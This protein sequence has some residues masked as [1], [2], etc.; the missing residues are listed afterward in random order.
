MLCIEVLKLLALEGSRYG[1]QIQ[2]KLNAVEAW[3]HYRDQKL[4]LFLPQ[5][6]S[7]SSTG[8]VGALAGGTLENFALPAPPTRPAADAQ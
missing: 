3:A 1:A 8:V 7:E 4:D 6:A 5:G 2:E